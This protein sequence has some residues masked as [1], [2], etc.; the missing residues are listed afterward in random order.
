M[1]SILFWVCALPAVWGMAETIYVSPR[2]NDAWTGSLK[3]PTKALNDGPLAT[4]EGARNRARAL[5]RSGQIAFDAPVEVEVLSGWYSID[6]P[7][8]FTFSDSHLHFKAAKNASVVVSGGRTLYKFEQQVHGMWQSDLPEGMTFEQL[9]INGRRAQR[10]KSPNEFYYYMRKPVPFGT[11]PVTGK[12]DAD[13]SRRA[14]MAYPE[15][16][17]NVARKRPDTLSEVVV[18]VFHSWEASQARLQ[19]VDGKTGLVVGTA[20]TPWPYF[21]WGGSEPRYVLENYREAL[22]C[23]GEW[24]ADYASGRLC[25]LPLKGESVDLTMAIAPVTDAFVKIYGENTT[26]NLVRD[27]AFDGISFR[28]A[29]YW[30]PENGQGDS[31]AAVNQPAAIEVRSAHDVVFRNCEIAHVGSHG[32]RFSEGCRHI[33]VEQCEIHDLGGGAVYVGDTT[34]GP[35]TPSSQL[36]GD[37]Q[38]YNC[39]LH[40]GGN[41]FPG[42]VGVWIGKAFGVSVTHCDISDFYY[43]GISM[44]WT[45]GYAPTITRNNEIS[46]NHIHHL[47]KEVLCDMGA[48]YTLGDQTGSVVSHNHIHDIW[49]S[50]YPRG[51]WGLYTDEG[52]ANLVFEK[53]LV[54]D[55]ATGCIHQHYGKNNLFRNNILAFSADGQ[56]QRSRIENHPTLCLTNNIIYWDNESP[57]ITRGWKG[58]A[59]SADD[60]R[61]GKNIYWNPNGF[62]DKAFLGRDW[63]GWQNESQDV[64]SVAMDPGFK[65]AA[66]RD[67]RLGKKSPAV[68]A[69]FEPFDYSE[70]GPVGKA[71][72]K[73]A[74]GISHRPFRHPPAPRSINLLPVY[75]DFED[76]PVGKALFE[77]K[78]HVEG[79]GDSVGVVEGVSYR[80]NRSLKFQDAQGL[81]GRFN[82]HV[83]LPCNLT[84]GVYENRFAFR[85][86]ANQDWFYEWRDYS[87]QGK[88]FVVG[89]GIYAKDNKLL[90]KSGGD[91]QDSRFDK[92]DI[93]PDTWMFITVRMEFPKKGAPVWSVKIERQGQP[94][95]EYKQ[96][97]SINPSFTAMQWLGMGSLADAATA[98]YIDDFFF[99]EMP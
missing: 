41:L 45:W 3:L 94:T 49:S 73:K 35:D 70:I 42:A 56:I 9:Y 75:C 66:R 93:Q 64:G 68:L 71:W 50:R 86:E 89:F 2:G 87:V 29:G 33:L 37:V 8:E 91:N 69:G 79:K 82:P 10:A 92:I 27:I 32:I 62:P 22:D 25:Y 21:N 53:N 61:F 34:V 31:Q 81:K 48:I 57:A 38:I 52:T 47:G 67:F 13:L 77:A 54:H 90:I 7:L 63:G 59:G 18:R 60:L 11:D 96:L 99:G 58:S 55:V 5:R 84:Q 65:N 44:G 97:A 88:E 17:E 16:L 76:I 24:Y 4:F 30:L 72:R 28:Y 26:S 74:D 19:H 78:V 20:A 23:P 95:A 39:I 46:Y 15:D 83:F 80:G 85:T 36:T 43:T 98:F 12:P 1:K 14:F 6:H 51:G 40:D